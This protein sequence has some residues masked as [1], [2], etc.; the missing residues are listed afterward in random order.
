MSNI[1]KGERIAVKR[2]IPII[3]YNKSSFTIFF[4]E[5]KRNEKKRTVVGMKKIP[6]R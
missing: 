5:K 6:V 1:T 4:L 3:K 2:N